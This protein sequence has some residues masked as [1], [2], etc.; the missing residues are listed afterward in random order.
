MFFSLLTFEIRYW[1]RQP[2]VWVFLL[3]NT[4]LL[5]WAT[6]SDDLTIGG[7]FGNI[8]K[9]APYVIRTITPSGAYWLC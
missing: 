3:I 4:L 5:A 6:A 7:S 1:L 2:M 9:N 8:Y